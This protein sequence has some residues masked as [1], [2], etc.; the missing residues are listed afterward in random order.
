MARISGRNLTRERIAHDAARL[1]AQDGIENYGL[2]K[3]K[4][5][6]Q[7]G[8]ADAKQ[9]PSNEEIAAAL[10]TY[11]ELYQ[12]NHGDE[13]RA[14]RELA[15]GVMHE[16]STFSPYLT[17][18]VLNGNAGRYATIELQLFSDNSKSVEHYL[19]SHDVKFR[20]GE[21]RLYCGDRAFRAPTFSFERDGVEI[22][23]ALLSL[24]E[25]RVQLKASADGKPIE[26]AGI[27]VVQ[28]LIEP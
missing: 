1:M 16:L 2:A 6:R 3:R 25:Q 28:A 17:G 9:L 18:P 12:Q 24:S 15:L 10:K 26:R 5:A 8:V 7:A 21:V 14:L 20:S 27:G 22:N 11:R 13:L 23:L 4:A 19:L